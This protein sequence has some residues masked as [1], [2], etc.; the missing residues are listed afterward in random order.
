MT[1]GG[2]LMR[3][4]NGV[5]RERAVLAFVTQWIFLGALA[6]LADF[7]LDTIVLPNSLLN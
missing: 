2:V 6:K 7:I 1:S 5:N 3:I 4:F